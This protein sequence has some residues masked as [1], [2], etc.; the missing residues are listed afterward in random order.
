MLEFG[1]LGGGDFFL[2]WQMMLSCYGVRGLVAMAL[3][4]QAFHGIFVRNTRMRLHTYDLRNVHILLGF[5]TYLCFTLGMIT[6]RKK[7]TTMAGR[8]AERNSIAL[9]QQLSSSHL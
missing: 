8:Y 6:A 4:L 7:K 1:S 5:T 2:L 9:F 3:E